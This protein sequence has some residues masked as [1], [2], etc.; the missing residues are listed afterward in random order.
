MEKEIKRRLRERGF[1]EEDLTKDELARLRREVQNEKK[2]RY[3]L[4]GVLSD[5]DIVMRKFRKRKR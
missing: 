2:G 1:T 3:A 4:D 5:M